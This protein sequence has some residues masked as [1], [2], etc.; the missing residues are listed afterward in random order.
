MA[1]ESHGRATRTAPKTFPSPFVDYYYC[2]C[3]CCCCCCLRWAAKG[4][5]PSSS[6]PPSRVSSSLPFP[7]IRTILIGNNSRRMRLEL[8]LVASL[9]SRSEVEDNGNESDER[10][11]S[12]S[13]FGNG[14]DLVSGIVEGNGC[15]E[16]G[17][18][19][20]LLIEGCCLAFGFP[21]LDVLRDIVEMFGKYYYGKGKIGKWKRYLEFFRDIN[22]GIESR[23]EL[24]KGN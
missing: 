7:W 3:C 1:A 18:V 16:C 9:N 5:N 6:H 8:F 14:N 23:V 12:K 24:E 13:V 4:H 11:K 19:N 21:C 20:W 17:V 15:V 22:F 10:P 2:Y